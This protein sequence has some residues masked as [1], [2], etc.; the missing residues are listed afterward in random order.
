M[1]N[2]RPLGPMPT[3]G[4]EQ[5][6]RLLEKNLP[7]VDHRNEVIEEIG[8]S[9]LGMRLPVLDIYLSKDL[10]AGSGQV[11]LSGPIVVG[12]ADTALYACIHAFYGAEVFAAI[13][14]LNVSFFR[15]GCI[16]PNIYSKSRTSPEKPGS[17]CRAF[18]TSSE[19]IAVEMS[20]STD[21]TARSR[22]WRQVQVM[23]ME[24]GSEAV[25][26]TVGDVRSDSPVTV[27]RPGCARCQ[28][29][30]STKRSSLGTI[31]TCTWA[32]ESE[33]QLLPASSCACRRS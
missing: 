5:L 31:G 28:R 11:V 22:R 15:V 24:G 3:L 33:G 32:A 2:V 17:I 27:Q 20:T 7:A 29:C 19:A 6:M 23:H 8:E 1:S 25:R 10:P 16:P 4:T 13:V 26:C 21:Y 9:S 14:N 12:F 30:A 18:C